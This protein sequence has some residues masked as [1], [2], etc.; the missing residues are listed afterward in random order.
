M[1]GEE[2]KALASGDEVVSG[3]DGTVADT[4]SS[5]ASSVDEAK[6][7]RKLDLYLIPLVMALYIFSFL[8]R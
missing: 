7:V 4:E 8:D 5:T 3:G 6:L 1:A 2:P